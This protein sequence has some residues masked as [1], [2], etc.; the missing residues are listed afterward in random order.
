MSQSAVL[1]C[2]SELGKIED[3]TRQNQVLYFYCKEQGMKAVRT[4][5][6]Y[7]KAK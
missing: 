5:I 3:L 1:W 6:E 2:R 4:I 7:G